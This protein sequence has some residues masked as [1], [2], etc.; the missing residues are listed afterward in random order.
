MMADKLPTFRTR[1]A[2]HQRVIQNPGSRVCDVYT[3]KFADDGTI[4]L[5][6]TGQE[7]TYAFIQSHRDSVDIHV[8]LAQ[9]ANGDKTALNR[10]QTMYLDAAELPKN[11]A[12]V[13]QTVMAGEDSFKQLPIEI[14]AKFEYNYGRWLASMGTD[15]W[16]S[17]MGIIN[18]AAVPDVPSAPVVDV[19]Q[20]IPG[21][22]QEVKE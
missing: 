5:E 14:R 1:Y 16:Y 4:A 10:R 9:Y 7:N 12:E 22:V 18:P 11:Y 19:T 21:P 8:L 17:K 2:R 3:P 15:D 20:P 13:L 6:V